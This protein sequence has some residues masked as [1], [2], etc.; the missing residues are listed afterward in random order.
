ML[1]NIVLIKNTKKKKKEIKVFVDLVLNFLL[2]VLNMVLSVQNLILSACDSQADVRYN[3]IKKILIL[4]V[5][6]EF[7]KKKNTEI[8]LMKCK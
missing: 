1:Y 8:I 7:I 4:M 6:T 3:K 2:A 5:F